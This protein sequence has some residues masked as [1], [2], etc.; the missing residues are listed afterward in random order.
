MDWNSKM[1]IAA[2][3]RE[4]AGPCPDHTFLIQLLIHFSFRESWDLLDHIPAERLPG[5]QSGSDVKGYST[6]MPFWKKS[7][8]RDVSSHIGGSRDIP[9]MDCEPGKSKWPKE[10]WKKLPH[11]SNSNC[12]EGVTQQLSESTHVSIHI[13]CILFFPPLTN[14]LLVSL[15]SNFVGTLLQSW[16]ARALSL[17]TGLMAR[18]GVLTATTWPQSLGG[19]S[20]PASS[21][22]R[23]KPPEIRLKH[24]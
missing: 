19:N 6:H 5:G 24:P 16:R 8:L 11:K 12:H 3:I 22:Y 13:Y 21:C 17:T 20:G 7:W 2:Q 23:L 1:K 10:S 9:N 14:T 15:L 18:I 4:E